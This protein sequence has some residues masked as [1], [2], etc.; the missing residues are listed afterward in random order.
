[1]RVDLGWSI[2]RGQKATECRY[3]SDV[4][5]ENMRE[6]SPSKARL[7][8]TDS[9]KK[10]FRGFRASA[11]LALKGRGDVAFRAGVGLH[12]RLDGAFSDRDN[13]PR[14][15]MQGYVRTKR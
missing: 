3:L 14:Y 6:G 12:W 4:S 7:R 1:M 10:E 9:E 15:F 11:K 8:R 2:R 5:K 13:V